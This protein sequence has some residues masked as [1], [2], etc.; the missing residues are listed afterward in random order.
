MET[1]SNIDDFNQIVAAL[2]E[3]LYNTFPVGIQLNAENPNDRAAATKFV[4]TVIWLEKEGF[5]RFDRRFCPE[6]APNHTVFFGLVLTAKG[7]AILNSV[8]EV[9]QEKDKSTIHQKLSKGLKSGSKE[10]IK[11]VVNQIISTAVSG[12]VQGITS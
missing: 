6:S 4:E 8:P 2:L 3:K 9:L 12:Y 7:L 1:I 11:I 5:V 10:A